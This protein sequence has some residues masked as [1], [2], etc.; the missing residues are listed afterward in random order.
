[1]TRANQSSNW[2]LLDKVEDLPLAD[3]DDED[4]DSDED[5]VCVS[6]APHAI[7][8]RV[9]GADHLQDPVNAHHSKQL[10][11]EQKSGN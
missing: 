10:Y 5:V 11:V 4:D 6:D 7:G 8:L 2:P 3:E 9:D 1:M